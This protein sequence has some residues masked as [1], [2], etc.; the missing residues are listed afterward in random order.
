ML[1][2]IHYLSGKTQK[3]EISQ[4]DYNMV[5]QQVQVFKQNGIPLPMFL[6]DEDGK[7][8]RVQDISYVS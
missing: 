6:T 4:P 7:P 3:I 2:V 1:A 5:R 8:V